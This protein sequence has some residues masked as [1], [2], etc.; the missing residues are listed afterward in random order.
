MYKSDRT[1]HLFGNDA[2]ERAMRNG[3]TTP[4]QNDEHRTL[5]HTIVWTID[6]FF[7]CTDIYI[8]YSIKYYSYDGGDGVAQLVERRTKDPKT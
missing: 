7:R 6:V 2:F 1:G 5:V 3:P 8:L 4:I